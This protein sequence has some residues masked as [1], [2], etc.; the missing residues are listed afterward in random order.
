MMRPK[1]QPVRDR[2]VEI[3]KEFD[4]ASVRHEESAAALNQRG[5]SIAAAESRGWA[6]AERSASTILGQT[7]I[8]IDDDYL[9]RGTLKDVPAADSA[10]DRQEMSD[11]LRTVLS[12]LEAVPRTN[13]CGECT[14]GLGICGFC[15]EVETRP[16]EP[17]CKLMAALG[18]VR[19]RLALL[20]GTPN[21][22]PPEPPAD[23]QYLGYC[24]GCGVLIEQ[25]VNEGS[26]SG[27]CAG[28]S[29]RPERAAG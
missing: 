8:E 7:V 26:E 10:K 22:T 11:L 21:P 20:E 27:H 18:A 23:S 2:L 24:L 15:F 16:H 13:D 5:Q 6:A 4:L 14:E 1:G 29:P 3:V 12:V 25:G 17:T 9:S 19:T 28:C